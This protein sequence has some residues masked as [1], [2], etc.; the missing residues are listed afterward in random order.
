MK[1]VIALLM[2][3]V[4]IPA[5]GCTKQDVKYAEAPEKVNA[6]KGAWEGDVYK[7]GFT[8]LTFTLPQGWEKVTEEELSE[9]MGEKDGITYDMMCQNESTGSHVMISYEELLKTAGK[10]SITE[11]DY[12]KIVSDNLYNMGFDVSDI[13]ETTLCGKTFYLVRAYGEGD[14]FRVNQYSLVR[15]EKG[16]MI[17]VII[18]AVNDDSFE[19]ISSNFS[20]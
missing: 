3:L 12:L 6:E 5:V 16:Y 20:E 17:S 4:M 15:Y 9:A 13:S 11:E 1:K 14:G 2:C 10:S 18:N 19:S 7:G 8:G